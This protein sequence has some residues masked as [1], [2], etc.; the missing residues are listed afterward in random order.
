MRY[1]IKNTCFKRTKAA[2]DDQ[3]IWEEYRSANLAAKKSVQSSKAT[4][5]KMA[6]NNHRT[7]PKKFW[8]E[9]SKLLGT[10]KDSTKSLQ[11]IRNNDGHILCDMEAA[12]Y[13]NDYYVSIGGKLAEKIGNNTWKAHSSFP[14][15]VGNN[16][17]FRIITEKEC[18]TL[19]KQ[20]DISKS[21]AIKDIKRCIS[22]IKF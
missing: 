4:Y 18:L 17:N 19:I 8:N 21:S 15:Q 6:L 1:L 12:E 14:H 5:I 10:G 20:I 7:D 13:M 3:L 16:F 2:P 11:T 9:V 22:A